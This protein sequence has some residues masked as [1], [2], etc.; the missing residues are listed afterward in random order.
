M[1]VLLAEKTNQIERVYLEEQ[2][3]VIEYPS[4]YEFRPTKE[5][6]YSGFIVMAK[7]LKYGLNRK[8]E[9]DSS[10]EDRVWDFV[11]AQDSVLYLDNI[12]D[13]AISR[14][15]RFQFDNFSEGSDSFWIGVPYPEGKT[16]NR[17]LWELIQAKGS[18]LGYRKSI[19]C[20]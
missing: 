5:E 14:S 3:I 6:D 1:P 19:W 15:T 2:D 4:G 16:R 20:V 7:T 9:V 10:L 13:L 8:G 18:Q 11:N 17:D 12:G